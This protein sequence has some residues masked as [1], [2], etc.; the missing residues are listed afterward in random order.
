MKELSNDQLLEELKNRF[1]QNTEMNR[2]QNKMLRQLEKL[3]ERLMQSEKIQSMF[4]SNIRNEINNPLTA[5]LG[6]SKDLA[7]G[8]SDKEKSQKNASL[9]FSES[10]LL[11]LQL[12]NI[13]VAA[14][15]E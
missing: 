14:E 13:F 4:L 5:I 11:S 10:F 7:N 9:I 2:Q 15:L 1:D 3:N 12:Q 8:N 6:L